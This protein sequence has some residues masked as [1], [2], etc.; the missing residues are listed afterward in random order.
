MTETADGPDRRASVSGGDEYSDVGNRRT[1]IRSPSGLTVADGAV[2]VV[3]AA[4]VAALLTDAVD[5][6]VVAV[7]VV[8]ATATP[9]RGRRR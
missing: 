3:V 8:V 6:R 2:V 1:R 7:T 4:L 5:L 9:G